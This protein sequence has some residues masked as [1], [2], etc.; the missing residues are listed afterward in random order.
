MKPESAR[1]RH[2]AIDGEDLLVH[3]WRVAQLT[4]LGL[5]WP[6][7]RAAAG[8]VDWHQVAKLVQYGCPPQLAVRIAG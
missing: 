4:R 6:E 5:P 7:A 2:E 3:E 1:E 8:R